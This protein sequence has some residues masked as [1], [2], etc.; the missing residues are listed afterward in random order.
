MEITGCDLIVFTFAAPQD[1]F[2]R[3][4]ASI[5]GRWP[6][7]LMDDTDGPPRGKPVA[8]LAVDQL[9]DGEAFVIFYRGRRDGPS[10]GRCGVCSDD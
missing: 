3:F 1:V 9:P 5:L 10:H 6:S 7:A 2:A 8:G 4:F